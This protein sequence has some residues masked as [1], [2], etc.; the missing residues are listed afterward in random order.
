ML[1][2]LYHKS[3]LGTTNRLTRGSIYAIMRHEFRPLASSRLR[4]GERHVAPADRALK[5]LY[6]EDN[7]DIGRVFAALVGLISGLEA[8]VLL[9]SDGQDGVELAINEKPD[10]IFMDEELPVMDGIEA[11]R[12]LRAQ[13]G[14][15]QVPVVMVSAHM[16][17]QDRRERAR[18]AG[19]T[20]WIGKP[21]EP[22]DLEAVLRSALRR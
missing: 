12:L 9:A 10:I 7:E 1:H 2:L 16:D 11:T 22:A 4:W 14:L 5:V 20:R 21:F 15:D 6:V 18:E 13:H 17:V 3:T 8:E 19:V